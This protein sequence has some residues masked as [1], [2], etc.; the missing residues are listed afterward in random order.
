MIFID[1]SIHC[2]A[3][4]YYYN[5]FEKVVYERECC[6]EMRSFCVHSAYMCMCVCVV[7]IFIA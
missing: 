3:A 6:V 5:T 1:Y 7:M 4:S 2:I